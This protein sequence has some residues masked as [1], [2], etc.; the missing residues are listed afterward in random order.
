MFFLLHK[1]TFAFINTENIFFLS[2]KK[3][4][5]EEERARMAASQQQDCRFSLGLILN[6][7]NSLRGNLRDARSV[8]GSFSCPMAK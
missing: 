8:T 2:L 6:L 5:V 1:K 4:G 7:Q 3:K